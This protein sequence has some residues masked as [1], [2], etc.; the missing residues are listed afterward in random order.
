MPDRIIG[1][2]NRNEDE[3]HWLPVPVEQPK[4]DFG[5]RNPRRSLLLAA[6]VGAALSIIGVVLL[7]VFADNSASERRP[8][9]AAGPGTAS[10]GGGSTTTTAA[11]V[12][13]RATATEV[14]PPR[15]PPPIGNVRIF[16][17]RRQDQ[18]WLDSDD[19][20]DEPG[21]AEGEAVPFMLQ[22]LGAASGAVY[23]VTIEYQCRTPAGAAF[24][25]LAGVSDEK[26]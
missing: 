22:L 4:P 1:R 16:V 26:D 9:S 12:T 3:W 7:L 11:S 15:S 2:R 19:V 13:A 5:S 25:H 20:K 17:W 23:D 14:T 18:Q 21:Y 24:D 8:P 10:A 6:A